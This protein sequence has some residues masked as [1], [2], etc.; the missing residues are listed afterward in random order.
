MFWP[1]S[2]SWICHASKTCEIFMLKI[3]ISLR[4]ITH[5]HV[6][7]SAAPFPPLPESIFDFTSP[8]FPKP[9]HLL[10]AMPSSPMAPNP[11]LP[12]L[13]WDSSMG[14]G[15]KVFL[16][17][18]QSESPAAQ[19]HSPTVRVAWVCLGSCCF[20][21]TVS[22]GPTD[23]LIRRFYLIFDMLYMPWSIS[24]WAL[25]IIVRIPESSLVLWHPWWYCEDW[26]LLDRDRKNNA[27]IIQPASQSPS[28]MAEELLQEFCLL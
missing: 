23:P 9:S 15:K 17:G 6:K 28:N 3:I 21:Q 10:G 4:C 12:A 20:L 13:L 14:S 1:L 5:L 11:A 22:T 2:D 19:V 24:C 8:A 26:W 27:S 16:R 18:L 7:S 25:C